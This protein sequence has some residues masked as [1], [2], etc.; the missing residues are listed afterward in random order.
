MQ[1]IGGFRKWNQKLA[2]DY[3]YKHNFLNCM[4]FHCTLH[5]LFPPTQ[6]T[7]Y[8]ATPHL[9]FPRWLTSPYRLALYTIPYASR[10]HTIPFRSHSVSRSQ[11]HAI[12][13]TP[14]MTILPFTITHISTYTPLLSSN[15]ICSAFHPTFHIVSS[16]HSYRNASAEAS[17]RPLFRAF[18]I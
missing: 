10:P 12:H 4:W 3:P 7:A 16:T 15:H 9:N 11:N 1:Y 2:V 8:C 17:T 14:C 13:R 5:I 18:V 6:L